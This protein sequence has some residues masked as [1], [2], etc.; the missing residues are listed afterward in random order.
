MKTEKS[1]EET[2]DLIVEKLRI[3]PHEFFEGIPHQVL[4][5]NFHKDIKAGRKS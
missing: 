3:K 4:H 1:A 5:R 2:G